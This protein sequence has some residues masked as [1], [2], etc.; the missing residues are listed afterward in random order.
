MVGQ[1]PT[2]IHA[3]VAGTVQ[4]ETLRLE[5]LANSANEFQLTKYFAITNFYDKVIS[6]AW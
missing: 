5:K 4:R 3:S 2:H 6:S 1:M